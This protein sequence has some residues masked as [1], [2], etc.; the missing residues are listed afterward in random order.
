[1]GHGDL[2]AEYARLG[3]RLVLVGAAPGLY[4]SQEGRDWRSECDW[5]RGAHVAI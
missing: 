4:G 2:F 3:A 5:W 1:V